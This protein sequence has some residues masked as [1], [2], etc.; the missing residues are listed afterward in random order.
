MQT[1]GKQWDVMC[2]SASDRPVS[3]HNGGS[4]R[5]R[6]GRNSGIART[7]QDEFAQMS[8]PMSALLQRQGLMAS[9]LAGGRGG[10]RRIRNPESPDG[11]M[12]RRSSVQLRPRAGLTHRMHLA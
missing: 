10:V 7:S 11:G 4:D 1:A 9:H 3:P 8:A 12:E 2:V 6:G 5:C